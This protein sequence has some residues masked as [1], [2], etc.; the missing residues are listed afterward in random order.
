MSVTVTGNFAVN[1]A[2]S[3][4]ISVVPWDRPVTKPSLSTVAISGFSEVN[5]AWF[6]MT[7]AVPSA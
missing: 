4:T 7:D 5:T 6:V 3:A 2:Y 1:P